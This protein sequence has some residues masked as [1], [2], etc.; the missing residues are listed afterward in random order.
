M[1]LWGW[2]CDLGSAE[3]LSWRSYQGSILWLPPARELVVV[4]LLVPD[5]RN[6]TGVI[7]KTG[8]HFLKKRFLFIHEKQRERGRDIAEEEAGSLWGAQFGT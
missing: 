1:I 4:S 8:P 7:G 5:I 2:Q 6:L 3:W